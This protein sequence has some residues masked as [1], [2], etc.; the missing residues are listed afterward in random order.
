MIKVVSD[1]VLNTLSDEAIRSDRLRKNLNFH[2]MADDPMQRM[3]NAFEPGT[4]IAP[5]KHENPDKRELFILIRG[6][7]LVVIF[8]ESGMISDYIFL[9]REKGN[10]AVEIAPKTW[11]TVISFE[12]GS[13]A[14]EIKDGPYCP[15]TDKN[16]APWA[17]PENSAEGE[18]YL[19]NL[20]DLINQSLLSAQ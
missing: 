11:H 15:D 3:L 10:F 12:K 13:I 14:F 18:V 2:K 16:Y 7:L 20:L 1:Q 17:P 4:Y 6:K 19:K 5:H 9:D 8:H